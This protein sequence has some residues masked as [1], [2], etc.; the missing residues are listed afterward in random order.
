MIIIEVK[1]QIQVLLLVHPPKAFENAVRYTIC[2]LHIHTILIK[3]RLWV[4]DRFGVAA[5]L[6]GFVDGLVGGIQNDTLA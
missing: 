1:T 5:C 2:L 6:T 4:F 3:E